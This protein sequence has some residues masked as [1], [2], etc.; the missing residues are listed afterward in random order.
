[1]SAT[2]RSLSNPNVLSTFSPGTGTSSGSVDEFHAA[3]SVNV[4]GLF[5]NSFA[6]RAS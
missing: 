5:A 2:I 6:T 3:V 4:V 1:M